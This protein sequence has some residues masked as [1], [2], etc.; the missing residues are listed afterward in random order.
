MRIYL[1]SRTWK[2]GAPNLENEDKSME[3]KQPKILLLEGMLW[4]CPMSYLRS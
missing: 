3:C 1:A 4:R 2:F